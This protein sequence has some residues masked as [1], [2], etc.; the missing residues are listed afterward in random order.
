[1]VAGPTAER[2]DDLQTLVDMAVDGRFTPL[3]DSR[4]PFEEIVAAHA[5]VETGRKRGSVLIAHAS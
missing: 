3:I 5:R 2:V 4:F 1:V